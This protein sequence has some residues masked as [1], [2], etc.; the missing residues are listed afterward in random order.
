[1][2]FPNILLGGLVGMGTGIVI[3]LSYV[4]SSITM[5]G[6][7]IVYLGFLNYLELLD[8]KKLVAKK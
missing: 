1:M 6:S 4:F 5:W 2:K 3:G 8:L 7:V